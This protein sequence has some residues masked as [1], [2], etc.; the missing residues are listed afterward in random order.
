MSTILK[1][2]CNTRHHARAAGD[3]LSSPDRIPWLSL[4]AIRRAA[5]SLWVLPICCALLAPIWTVRYPVIV[6]YPNHLASAY[7]LAHLKDASFHF[8][9]Y[10][11][12]HWSLTPY[13]T[14]DLILLALQKVM[15]IDIAG[16]MLLSL[17]VLAVPGATWFFIRSANPE[18]EGLA[19]WSLLI[20]YNLYFLLWGMLNLQL[21]LALC[22]L[23]IGVWLRHLQRPRAASWL[24]LLALTTVLYLTHFMSF[25]IAG[26]VMVAYIIITGRSIRDLISSLILFG[27]GVILFVLFTAPAA[28]CDW[29]LTYNWSAKL[30]GISAAVISGVSPLYDL[31]NIAFL[32]AVLCLTVLKNSE[33]RC[34]YRWS[35]VSCSLFALYWVVPASLGPGINAD[36]R[37]MPVVLILLL[38]AV[39]VGRQ[40]HALGVIA[41]L[42]FGVRVGAVEH[43]FLWMQRDSARL[44]RAVSTIPTGARVIPITTASDHLQHFW[45]YGVIQREWRSPCLF[46]NRGVQ[47]LRTAM[48]SDYACAPVLKSTD[49]F[50]WERIRHDFDYAWVYRV[51]EIGAISAVSKTIYSDGDLSIVQF[52]QRTGLP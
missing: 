19:L 40:R 32:A 13:L 47:P 41:L 28:S 52:Q 10:Y 8:S 25:A 9:E 48:A 16:R 37:L 4:G 23:V 7:V 26:W 50:P 27:P 24:L 44:A 45:A 15:S 39:K 3:V 12:A 43:Y 20:S 21:G 11:A 38:A 33:F 46:Q 42:L 17:C 6:D 14:M 30:S 51:P 22:L 31:T 18:E 35:G 36:R 29:H 34:D 49:S 1:C 5:V 2:K